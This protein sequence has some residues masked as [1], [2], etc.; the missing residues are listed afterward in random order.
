VGTNKFL[1]LDKYKNISVQP[2][3]STNASIVP[4]KIT[5]KTT[6]IDEDSNEMTIADLS[7]DDGGDVMLHCPL[8]PEAHTNND[9]TPSC[10][11]KKNGDYLNLNCFGCGNKTSL[12]FGKGKSKSSGKKEVDYS[13]ADF[14]K[15]DVVKE[16][17]QGLNKMELIVDELVRLLPALL[18]KEK[19][20][21]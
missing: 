12:F 13:L 17:P 3:T 9:A 2:D 16:M 21:G 5:K 20:N 8:S 18:K 7:L 19:K 1:D 14:N 11:M 4:K 10:S 15:A 6:V